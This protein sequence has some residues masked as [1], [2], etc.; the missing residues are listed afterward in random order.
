MF[1]KTGLVLASIGT[2]IGIVGALGVSRLM[3][4]L[5]YE[6]SPLDPTTYILVGAILMVAAVLASYLPARRA[7]RTDPLIAL[8]SD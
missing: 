3:T 8:R 1:V 4:S 6:V 5:L 2:G 7:A